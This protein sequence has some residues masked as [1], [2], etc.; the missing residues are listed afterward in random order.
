MPRRKQGESFMVLDLAMVSWIQH[1]EHR[2]QNKDQQ[3]GLP[4]N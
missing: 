4:Q 1:Q 2:Q 3:M